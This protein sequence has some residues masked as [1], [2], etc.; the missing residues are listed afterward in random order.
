M[1]KRRDESLEDILMQV[2]FRSHTD[3]DR[4]QENGTKKIKNKRIP[5]SK[6][7]DRKFQAKVIQTTLRIF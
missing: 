3:A 5:N 1:E 2:E 6:S 7:L 4:Q